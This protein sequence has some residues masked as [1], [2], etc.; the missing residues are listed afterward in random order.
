MSKPITT[1]SV[2][3]V[4]T[5]SALTR[6]NANDRDICVRARVHAVGEDG[7]LDLDFGLATGRRIVR[8]S[9]RGY[10]AHPSG[11]NLTLGSKLFRQPE[12]PLTWHPAELCDPAKFTATPQG[13]DL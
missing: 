8:R 1:D 10:V 11:K 4:L 9:D 3:H 6:G 7:R 13:G 12:P 5:T 2:V